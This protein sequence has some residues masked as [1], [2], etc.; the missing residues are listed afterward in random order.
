MAMTFAVFVIYGV[1]A[2]AFRQV[3]V[4][5]PRAQAWVRRTFAVAFAGLGVRLALAERGALA[6]L[7]PRQPGNPAM[8]FSNPPPSYVTRGNKSW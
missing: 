2:H 5:S 6:G 3:V 1:L 4:E 8:N 7:Q